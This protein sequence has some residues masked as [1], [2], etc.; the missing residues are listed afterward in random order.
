M[1]DSGLEIGNL[2]FNANMISNFYGLNPRAFISELKGG[3][4]LSKG[5]KIIHRFSED[6]DIHIM[7]F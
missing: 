5:H 7:L 1:I 6:T 4:A 3:A 2:N